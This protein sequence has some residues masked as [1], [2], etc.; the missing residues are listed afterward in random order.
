MEQVQMV[1][2]QEPVEDGDPAMLGKNRD[3]V[4]ARDKVVVKARAKVLA[5]DK[6][7]KGKTSK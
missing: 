7:T 2:A 3:V 5:K 4:V 6:A 1:R